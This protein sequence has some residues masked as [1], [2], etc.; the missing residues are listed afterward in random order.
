MPEMF[1]PNIMGTLL[2]EN[3]AVREISAMLKVMI[4]FGILMAIER[5]ENMD[6][7]RR[8]FTQ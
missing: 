1:K 2:T 7:C 5:E 4:A 8:C 6:R 3:G